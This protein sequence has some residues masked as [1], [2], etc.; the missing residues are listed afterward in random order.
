MTPFSIFRVT[1]EV[2]HLKARLPR[3]LW[4][5]S[6]IQED[7]FADTLTG[8]RRCL[9][10]CIGCT[11]WIVCTVKRILHLARPTIQRLGNALYFERISETQ[12]MKRRICHRGSLLCCWLACEL[13]RARAVLGV[14]LVCKIWR[15]CKKMFKTRLSS[16]I[17]II[18]H[19]ENVSS[20][21]YSVF[22]PQ[23]WSLW[24]FTLC[25]T[26]SWELKS[27]TCIISFKLYLNFSKIL[28]SP[29]DRGGTE[30]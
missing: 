1:L 23:Q 16:K 25:Q 26:L 24:V 2:T 13:G 4:S 5:Q 21:V 29:L 20:R 19:R 9:L 12:Q 8:A 3:G 6:V 28:L 27:F 7:E 10:L 18:R 11:F 22:N 14:H 15:L 17:S 30:A